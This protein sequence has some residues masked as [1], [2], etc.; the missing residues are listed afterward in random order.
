MNDDFDAPADDEPLPTAGRDEILQL[1]EEAIRESHKK[2]VDGRV[3]DKDNERIR[4]GWFQRLGQLAN[5][6]NRILDSHDEKQFEEL[7]AKFEALSE[8]IRQNQ[9]DGVRA[10]GGSSA[11]DD[12]RL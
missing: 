6:Y 10:D 7:E 2:A 4:Q 5:Q 9:P 1:L 3:Y 11:S 8:E 12:S